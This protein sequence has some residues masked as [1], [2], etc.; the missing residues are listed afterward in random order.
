LNHYLSVDVL[1]LAE[2]SLASKLGLDEMVTVDCG[3]H[4]DLHV[5]KKKQCSVYVEKNCDDFFVRSTAKD[6]N[7]W[8]KKRKDINIHEEDRWK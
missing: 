6:K 3:G 8:K 1:C 5:K 2:I 7:D 4:G